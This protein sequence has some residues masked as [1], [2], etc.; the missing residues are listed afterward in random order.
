MIGDSFW[1]I[2]AAARARVRSIGVSC[3][4]T[5]AAELA[6][7]GASEVFDDAAALLGQVDEVF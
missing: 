6:E 7:C 4:G 3:G 5:G 1:D 2:E